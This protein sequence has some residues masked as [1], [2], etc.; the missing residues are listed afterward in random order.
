MRLI[1]IFFLS[2]AYS[3][4]L[5]L[6]QS[7]QEDWT[8]PT[9]PDRTSSAQVGTSYTISWNSNLKSWF[10]TYCAAC[11]AAKVDLW[12]TSFSSYEYTYKIASGINVVATSSYRWNVDIDT[13]ALLASPDWVFRFVP[14]GAAANNRQQ[15]S[16]AGFNIT[17]PAE[18]SRF[19]SATS[20]KASITSP[21]RDTSGS[22]EAPTSSAVATSQ[23]NT[24]ATNPTTMPPAITN[25]TPAPSS[26]PQS[27]AW[28]AGVIIGPIVGI[29]LGASLLWLLIRR[30]RKQRAE[31]HYQGNLGYEPEYHPAAFPRN[32]NATD[33]NTVLVGHAPMSPHVSELPPDSQPRHL[34][35]GYQAELP[36]P[37]Q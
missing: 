36:A 10:P 2:I 9:L 6:C 11:D 33:K 35:A 31:H 26:A 15:I 23:S 4:F 27:K 3:P 5:A 13:S 37:L 20:T 7:V 34:Q 21:A 14:S 25:S 12:V 1:L 32:T 24:I 17:A 8:A 29:A 18:A 16:S 22:V 30:K 19:A 28:I